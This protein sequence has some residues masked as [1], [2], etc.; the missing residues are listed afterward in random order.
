MSYSEWKE[1]VA[2]AFVFML[3]VLAVY[4]CITLLALV[5]AAQ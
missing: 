1:L 3:G 4:G 5:G 2:S